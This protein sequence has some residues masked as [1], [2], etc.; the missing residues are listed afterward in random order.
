MVNLQNRG[1]FSKF[2]LEKIRGGPLK[3]LFKLLGVKQNASS[4]FHPQSDGQT[5]RVNQCME[6][7]LRCY[8]SYQQ[9]DWLDLLP[10]AEFTYNNTFQESIKTSPFQANF[11]FQP[12]FD[13]Q[14]VLTPVN[15]EAENRIERI[16]IQQA[17]LKRE[18]CP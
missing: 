15:Q 11:G 1:T 3:G 9:D 8:V 2:A 7:Y 4:A 18:V 5:E 14:P 6:Q 13:I 12:R 10:M 17:V 16:Q